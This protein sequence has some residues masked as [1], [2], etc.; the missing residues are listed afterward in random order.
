MKGGC[1]ASWA[2]PLSQFALKIQIP[3]SSHSLDDTLILATGT[4]IQM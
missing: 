3:T 2:Q 4:V 1:A